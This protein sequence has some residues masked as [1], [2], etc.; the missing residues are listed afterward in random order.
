[1]R[2]LKA[3]SLAK[4]SSSNYSMRARLQK[5]PRSNAIGTKQGLAEG[6]V[7][8]PGAALPYHP[9][10]VPSQVP[11]SIYEIVVPLHGFRQANVSQ[12]EHLALKIMWPV[13]ARVRAD[14]YVAGTH[15]CIARLF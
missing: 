9:F 5:L 8:V 14:T 4:L 3:T 2:A 7:E 13:M 15:R 11:S 6:S 1:M 10:A 12:C